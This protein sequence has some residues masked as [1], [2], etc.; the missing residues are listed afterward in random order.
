LPDVFGS[1]KEITLLGYLIRTLIVGAVGYF[2]GR[3]VR[4][5]AVSQLT[6]Y[7]FALIWILGAITVSPLLDGKVSFNYM[8]VPLLTLFFW[9]TAFSLIALKNRRFSFFFN[10]K[11]AILIENGKVIL[12]N[13]KKQFLNVELLLSELRS[14]DVFDISEVKYAVLEPNGHISVMKYDPHSQVTPSELN[15]SAKATEIPLIVIN[16]GKLV[17][18]NLQEAGVDEIWLMT[19]LSAQNVTDIKDVFLSTVDRSK[20]LFVLKNG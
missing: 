13:L 5:R 14:Y 3:I 17:K 19:Q 11:P 1:I 15:L 9:H 16:E 8:I 6:T 4:R 18:E 2:V 20:K 7:D 12:K 10:G